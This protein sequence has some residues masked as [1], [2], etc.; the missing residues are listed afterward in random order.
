MGGQVALAQA[1]L[2]VRTDPVKAM[3]LL[4]AARLMA[5]GTLVEEAA[6]RREIFVA[7][8]LHQ[9]EKL[10]ALARAYLDRFRHS[11]YAGNFRNRLLAAVSHMD[12]SGGA[13]GLA[14]LDRMLALAEPDSRRELYL[15]VALASVISGRTGP[16]VYAAGEAV[17][18]AIDGSADALRAHLY[19]AA[20]RIVDAKAYDDAVADLKLVDRARL[21]ES[22]AA[23]YDAV[24]TRVGMLDQATAIP[25]APPF[26][27]VADASNKPPVDTPAIVQRAEAAILTADD[28]LKKAS[29]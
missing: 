9:Q 14:R 10:Q 13:E 7:D 17:K 27:M 12:F 16:A 11:V 25:D 8:Q 6:L 21:S 26:V 18:L 2:A 24:A 19:R 22:D 28:I 5:P 1:A 29:Q 15:T 20:S 3:A 4:D 23:I